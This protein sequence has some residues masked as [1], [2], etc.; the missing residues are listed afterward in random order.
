MA[1]GGRTRAYWEL[2]G[3]VRSPAAQA[4]GACGLAVPR[5]AI[6]TW[7][8]PSKGTLGH[9]RHSLEWL[10]RALG[11]ALAGSPWDVDEARAPARPPP[12]LQDMSTSTVAPD[13]GVEPNAAS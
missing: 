10:G 4:P 2:A 11:R 6:R 12:E 8:A 5:V 13:P 9:H 1:G 7:D 3:E